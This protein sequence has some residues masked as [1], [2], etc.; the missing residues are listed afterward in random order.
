[1]GNRWGFGP[2]DFFLTKIGNRMR[3]PSRTQPILYGSP[4]ING[5][6]KIEE[7][8]WGTAIPEPWHDE[9][10]PRLIVFPG[11]PMADVRP[12]VSLVFKDKSKPIFSKEWQKNAY[13][14]VYDPKGNEKAKY[15]KTMIEHGMSAV[16]LPAWPGLIVVYVSFKI[17]ASLSKVKTAEAM[18]SPHYVKPDWDNTVKF[19]MDVLQ[20][21]I[22]PSDQRI[23]TGFVHKFYGLNPGVMVYYSPK[24]DWDM[25]QTGLRLGKIFTR[26]ATTDATSVG[27]G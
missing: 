16:P 22:I 18:G 10:S 11:D 24:V 23:S 19:Y 15:Q 3:K 6:G 27:E 13:L 4:F 21:V 1:M 8:N 20:D 26:Y 25:I 14:K 12:R 7:I 5:S 2:G 9:A 17:P